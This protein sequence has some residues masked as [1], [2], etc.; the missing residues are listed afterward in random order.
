MEAAAL[1]ARL[2]DPGFTPGKRELGAVFDLL[3]SEDDELATRAAQALARAREAAIAPAIERLAAAPVRA[4]RRLVRL[5]SRLAA[6]QADPRLRTALLARLTDPDAPTRRLSMVALGKLPGDGVED[7]LLDALDRAPSAERRALVASLGKIGSSRALAALSALAGGDV[8]LERVRQRALL[9]LERSLERRPVRIVLDRRLP[10][11]ERVV[12]G[13]RAG[14]SRMLMLEL[15][16]LKPRQ[17]STAS[18]ELSFGG[19]LGEL[20]VARLAS[21]FALELPLLAAAT[22]EQAAAATLSEDRALAVLCGWSDGRPTF[23]LNFVGGGHRRRSVFEIAE[24]V[25]ARTDS[26]VNDPRQAAWEARIDE[27]A[28]TLW[29]VPMGFEDPR[30]FYRRAD[31][32]A[33]SHPTIAAALARAAGA[34]PNDVVWDPFCGSGL[35]LIERGLLGP[36]RRLIGSDLSAAAIQAADQNFRASGLANFELIRAPAGAY[37]PPDVNLILTNPPMGRRVARGHA[38]ALLLEFLKHAVRLLPRSG[39]V[40]W[41]SP[42]ARDDMQRVRALGWSVDRAESLDLGGFS[43]ELQTLYRA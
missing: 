1:T 3:D 31:V 43:A 11:A 22:L 36:Y 18:V 26:I 12:V 19:A 6:E 24:L 7:A 29:L 39:R 35:E 10:H 38:A 4:R 13:C 30:F 15:A 27:R 34:S 14:L 16:H 28:R 41:L 20:F 21:E 17:R 8:E 5:L 9:M 23:R 25:R 42:L 2:A 40:V 32:P 37:S 33:A